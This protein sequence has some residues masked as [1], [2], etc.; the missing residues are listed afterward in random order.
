VCNKQKKSTDKTVEKSNRIRSLINSNASIT[1]YEIAEALGVHES[2][3][4]G[5]IKKHL[6]ELLEQMREN[7]LSNK[8]E[9]EKEKANYNEEIKAELEIINKLFAENPHTT[10]IDIY[11]HGIKEQRLLSII[12]KHGASF[13]FD[14]KAR[15]DENGRQKKADSSRDKLGRAV[16]AVAENGYECYFPS[17]RNAII[18]INKEFGSGI[19]YDRVKY[20]LSKAGS[21][22][23]EGISFT[24]V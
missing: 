21:C 4:R 19:S 22:E 14:I 17:V 6:P 10:R 23:S 8:R 20:L 7:A 13:Y 16:K 2:S 15:L 18:E 24:F 12:T 5:C 1:Y 3:I 11:N 9:K